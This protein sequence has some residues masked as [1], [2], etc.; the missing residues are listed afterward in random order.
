MKYEELNIQ[1]EILKNHWNLIGETYVIAKEKYKECYSENNTDENIW[2]YQKVFSFLTEKWKSIYPEFVLLPIE[3]QVFELFYKIQTKGFEKEKYISEAIEK[4][5]VYYYLSQYFYLFV[6]PSLRDNYKYEDYPRFEIKTDDQNLLLY[7]IFGELWNELNEDADDEFG[8][9]DELDLEE[10]NDIEFRSL[11]L[12]LSECWNKTKLKTGSKVIATL[13][14]AT[15][16]GENYYLDENRI[17]SDKELTE[18]INKN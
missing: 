6:I 5:N 13:S 1:S 10:F 8:D 9:F 3:N 7:E 14:E 2:K 18:I 4:F 17:L 15:S 11:G 12:F 16:V